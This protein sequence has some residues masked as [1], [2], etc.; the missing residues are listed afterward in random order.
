MT[1]HPHFNH[2]RQQRI[3]SSRKKND[4]LGVMWATNTNTHTHTHITSRAAKWM[5]EHKLMRYR[6]RWKNIADVSFMP[7]TLE[8]LNLI[9]LQNYN[10]H[11]G[12]CNKVSQWVNDAKYFKHKVNFL[13]IACH[14]FFCNIM[15]YLLF[16]SIVKYY[17]QW[18]CIH[19]LITTTTDKQLSDM[20]KNISFQ[21]CLRNLWITLLNSRSF[22]DNTWR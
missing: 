10:R 9:Q 18:K 16:Y 7:Q 22:L 21:N 4:L 6:V 14:T 17:L 8:E 3:E 5:N 20:T 12:S 11:T 19:S 1:A 15:Q 13:K 2:C